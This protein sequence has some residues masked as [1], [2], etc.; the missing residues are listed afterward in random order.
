[1]RVGGSFRGAGGIDDPVQFFLVYS[2]KKQF[3]IMIQVHSGEG[4]VECGDVGGAG[5]MEC[6]VRKVPANRTIGVDDVK[7]LV[8]HEFSDQL[9]QFW[10]KGNRYCRLICGE[11]ITAADPH[12]VRVILIGLVIMGS[13]N[14]YSMV[15]PA[16]I[17]GKII[18]VFRYAAG[19]R[20]ERVRRQEY[21]HRN[22]S[23]I[24]NPAEMSNGL[25]NVIV[26]LSPIAASIAEMTEK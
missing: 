16:Q 2:L 4:S 23:T 1:M 22:I 9:R 17:P 11:K 20:I 24:N 26:L 18:H 12:G 7:I 14:S 13:E 3:S 10:M 5:I 6:P 21:I 8:T 19:M 25:L 15:R